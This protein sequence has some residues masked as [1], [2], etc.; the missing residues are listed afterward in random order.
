MTDY[1]HIQMAYPPGWVQLPVADS[2]STRRDRELD[3]WAAGK[4]REMLGQNAPAEDVSQRARDLAELT[5]A[6]RIRRDRYGVAYYPPGQPGLIAMLDVKE[7]SPSREHG[8]ISFGLL[9]QIYAQPTADTVGDIES[10]EVD[11]PAGPALRVRR[12]QV[13]EPDPAGQG[14][15]TESV[16]YAIHPSGLADAAVMTM[17]WTSAH[18]GDELAEMADAIARTIRISQARR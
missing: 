15:L 6:C 5:V 16:T 17:S 3:A 14:T 9:H 4:A 11:L 18:V 8:Q 10:S 1:L 13:E 7:L 2:T 12:K